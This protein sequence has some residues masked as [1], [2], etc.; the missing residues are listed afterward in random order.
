MRFSVASAA[1]DTSLMSSLSDD[2]E[3]SC[4]RQYSRRKSNHSR[5]AS[6]H[7]TLPMTKSQRAEAL[8]QC[9]AASSSCATVSSTTSGVVLI[10]LKNPLTEKQYI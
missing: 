10:L 3:G 5:C 1:F 7:S 4:A 8:R 6:V 2:G 9:P